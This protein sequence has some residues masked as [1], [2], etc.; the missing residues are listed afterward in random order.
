MQARMLHADHDLL[1]G[2]VDTVGQFGVMKTE[3][4]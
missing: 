1:G 4:R 2:L 3:L